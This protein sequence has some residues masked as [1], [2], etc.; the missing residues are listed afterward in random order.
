MAHVEEKFLL[1]S[2]VAVAGLEILYVNGLD[3]VTDISLSLYVF[4]KLRT[5]AQI[6]GVWY[7]C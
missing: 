5:P 6:L 3:W 7:L 2:D 4:R 1:E